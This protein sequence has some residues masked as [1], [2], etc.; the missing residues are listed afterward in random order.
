MVP[1]T[2]GWTKMVEDH[3]PAMEEIVREFYANLY[4]KRGDFFQTWIRRREIE[5]IPTLIRNISGAPLVCDPVYPWP[6]DHFP[7]RAEIVECFAKRRPHKM[8]TEAKGSFQMS[9]FSNN[10]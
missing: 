5:L 1:N 10:V 3:C 4:Q 9:D 8:K 2:H 6:V 7:T